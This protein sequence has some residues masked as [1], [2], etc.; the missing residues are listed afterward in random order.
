[1]GL[2]ITQL[3]LIATG[4]STCSLAMYILWWHKSFDVGHIASIK[5]P[6]HWEEHLKD[7]P[8]ETHG[9][10]V[11]NLSFPNLSDMILGSDAFRVG[12]G[13]SQDFKA[14]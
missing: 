6:K 3:E 9:H 7:L 8:T 12:Y 13:L 1:M 11:S 5:C 2:S 4:F 10:G 14:V